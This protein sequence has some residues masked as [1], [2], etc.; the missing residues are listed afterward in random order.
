M[1]EFIQRV[2]SDLDRTVPLRNLDGLDDI[3]MNIGK[4][5]SEKFK[6]SKLT[7]LVKEKRNASQFGP[8]QIP[9]KVY[10]KCLR[11]MNHIYI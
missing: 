7:E 4:F 2:A 5:N 9:Y 3:S 8:N 11:I 10:K 6:I 1:N